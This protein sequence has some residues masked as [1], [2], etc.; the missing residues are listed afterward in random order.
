MGSGARATPIPIPL[1]TVPTALL[2]LV[3]VQEQTEDVIS[4]AAPPSDPPENTEHKKE[5]EKINPL[6]P[7]FADF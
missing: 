1:T 3:T 4:G 5:K 7:D 2:A 6:V